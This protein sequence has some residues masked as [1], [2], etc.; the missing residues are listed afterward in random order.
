MIQPR[1]CLASVLIGFSLLGGPGLLGATYY[2]DAAGGNDANPGTDPK[3]AWRGLGKVNATVF[4]PG[5]RILLRAGT[6]YPG[7]LSPQGSGKEGQPIVIDRYGDGAKPVIDGGGAADDG[8]FYGKQG[9][10][11]NVVYL[12]NQEHWEISNLEIVNRGEKADYRR[13]VRVELT[14]MGVCHHIHLKNLYIH[15]VNGLNKSKGK[16]HHELSKQ[17]GGIFLCVT[18]DDRKTR[19]SDVLI[20]GCTV[21]NCDRSGISVGARKHW[22]P[23]WNK[24]IEPALVDTLLHQDVVIRNNAIDDVG[25]D[26]IV[27]QY[28]KSPLVEHNVCKDAAKRSHAQ[29]QY[30]AGIWPWMC[31]DALF[32]YNEVYNTR[33][34]LDGQGFDCDSSR[35]TVYQ[36]NYSHDNEGG[37]ML[38]CQGSSVGSVVR[39]NVSQNDRFVL[40]TNSG[41]TAQVYNNVFYIGP[42]LDTD[43]NFPGAAGSMRIYNNIFYNE[44]TRKSPKWG[45]YAYDSNAYFGFDTQ[46]NDPRKLVADPKL[47]APGKAEARATT[48]LATLPLRLAVPDAYRLLP[49]SPCINRG[50]FIGLG[51]EAGE[52]DAWGQRLYNGAPDIGAF[53]DTA[54]P[55]EAVK[56]FLP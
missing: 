48:P 7:Q 50:R 9:K 34:R 14:D 12:L 31:E 21:R 23:E 28:C 8:G 13:G 24:L 11:G 47:A 33:S 2:V 5:D 38:F 37:F 53:E 4:Q 19:F 6:T 41:G 1:R 43:V 18:G 44:G 56:P 39:Y 27:V 16:E 54:K 36:Y 46:P 22:Y 25:G 42:G 26:G 3:G 17:T 32:Q 20:E 15:D 55:Y 10:T 52:T 40:F 49:D 35:G 30:S 29:G 45:P 51:K